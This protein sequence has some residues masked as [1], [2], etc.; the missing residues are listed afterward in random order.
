M[1]LGTVTLPDDLL[2]TNE[3]EWTPVEQSIEYTLPGSMIVETGVKQA[4][5]PIILAG[6][7]DHGWVTRQTVIDLQALE[8]DPDLEMT[9]T[10]PDARELTV[11]FDRTNGLPVEARPLLPME[12]HV[13]GDFYILTLRLLEV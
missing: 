4:G 11:I 6:A 10:L 1:I 5:R 13:A 2:W 7:D 9:L 12:D 3:F 8:A